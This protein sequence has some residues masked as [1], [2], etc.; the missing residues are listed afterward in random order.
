ML[1]PVSHCYEDLCHRQRHRQE[2]EFVYDPDR[3]RQLSD[4]SARRR[5]RSCYRVKGFSL[6]PN[7]TCRINLL[8]RAVSNDSLHPSNNLTS[9]SVRGPVKKHFTTPIRRQGRSSENAE[10]KLCR[11][12]AGVYDMMLDLMA[13]KTRKDKIPDGL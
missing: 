11:G 3:H 5:I 7:I 8:L 13:V 6:H 2:T 4:H 9:W 10:A 12:D 1:R